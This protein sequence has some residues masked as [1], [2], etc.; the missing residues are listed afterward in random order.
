MGGGDFGS[1][2]GADRQAVANGKPLGGNLCRGH[3]VLWELE[4][5]E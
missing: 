5:R 1:A 2:G 3:G 4:P